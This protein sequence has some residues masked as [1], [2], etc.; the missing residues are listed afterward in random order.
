MAWTGRNI[1]PRKVMWAVAEIIWGDD[2]GT[3]FRVPRLR[4]ETHTEGTSARPERTVMQPKTMFPHFRRRKQDEDAPA[5]SSTRR[6]QRTS[7]TR[8]KQ[9]QA[10]HGASY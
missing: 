1:E 7:P 9:R 4:T 2:S 5:K 10:A 8:K 3:S 6:L